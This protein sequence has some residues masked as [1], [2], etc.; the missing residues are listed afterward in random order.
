MMHPHIKHLKRHRNVLYGL[1]VILLIIQMLSFLTLSAKVSQ[2][3]ASQET[4][5]REL[6]KSI[7]GVRQDNQYKINEVVREIETQRNDFQETLATQKSDFDRQINVLKASQQ[8]FSGIIDEVI[9]GVVTIS[10]DTSAGSGFVIHS[11]GY[12]VTNDHLIEGAK[13]VKVKTYI[14]TE[15]TAQ[16][17]GRDA[18]GDLALLKIPG[19]FDRISVGDSDTL[20]IGEKVIAIGNP[21]GLS[22]TVTEG[23][24][25]ALHREGPNGRSVYI[26]TDVTLN[27]GN[28]GGPLINREGEVIGV[29]NFKVGGAEGLGFA[30]E[31]NTVKEIINGFVN[32]TLI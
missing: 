14:G 31:S 25:S 6:G 16:I 26:Q 1:V 23:I 13:F 7:E 30:L 24:V 20:Q 4:I 18:S 28:S 3:Q 22:F 8:D 19:V 32:E 29:N 9:R 21:L 2:L 12:V 27:P 5:G 11:A 15:Y 17:V 10:T